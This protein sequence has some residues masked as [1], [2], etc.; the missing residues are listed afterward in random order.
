MFFASFLQNRSYATL[1]DSNCLYSSGSF[2]LILVQMRLKSIKNIGKITKSMKMIA[3]TKLNRAQ[4]A[5]EIGKT[6]SETSTGKLKVL[7]RL[8][9]YFLAFLNHI[10]AGKGEE[11]KTESATSK[12]P[13]LLIA[14]SS[15]RGLCGA[16]H[17]SVSKFTRKLIAESSEKGQTSQIIVLGDKAKPQLARSNRKNIVM[18]FNQVG[19]DIPTFTDAIGIVQLILNQQATATN[20]EDPSQPDI[21]VIYNAFKSVIAYETTTLPV[22]TDKQ[23]HVSPKLTAYEYEDSALEAYSQFHFTSQVFRA[24]VEGHASEMSAKRMAMENASKNSDAI[25]L[26]LTMI[27][28]RTRQSVITNELVD[29]ITGASAL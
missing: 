23:L 24:L 14:C 25:V 7:L 15:D 16:I 11:I 2:I 10:E 20:A 3:S 8:L 28:N 19:K 17:S 21:K 12:S 26:N 6:F 1:K 13:Q 9:I 5:M 27:Y 4:K 29:I 22:F 18:S